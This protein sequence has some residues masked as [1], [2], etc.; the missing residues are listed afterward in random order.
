[1]S[2]STNY[3]PFVGIT[4][5]GIHS[6]SLGLYRVGDGSRYNENLLPSLMDKT[7]E[8][9]SGDGMYYFGT[10]FQQKSWTLDFAFD[11]VNQEQLDSIMRLFGAAAKEPKKLVFDEHRDY[12]LLDEQG[13][14]IVKKY[15]L[16]KVVEIPTL[17]TICFDEKGKDGKWIDIYKGEFSVELVNYEGLGYKGETNYYECFIL[18]SEDKEGIEVQNK[19]VSRVYPTF[20]IQRAAESESTIYNFS[21]LSSEEVSETDSIYPYGLTVNN[22]EFQLCG[23]DAYDN[24]LLIDCEK[25]L[26]WGTYNGVKT[27]NIYNKYISSGYFFDLPV[28]LTETSDKIYFQG[29]TNNLALYGIRFQERLY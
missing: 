19:G 2:T 8:R 5:D 28:N 15:Y 6:S 26:I 16:A 21:I 10:N 4:F 24:G 18:N 20:Y 22:L 13:V 3:I 9:P 29:T 1:M 17:K 7:T 14:P 25:G 11:N 27:S 12:N 23:D